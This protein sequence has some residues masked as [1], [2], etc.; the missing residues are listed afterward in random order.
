MFKQLECSE[1]HID[2]SFLYHFTKTKDCRTSLLLNLLI[3][4]DSKQNSRNGTFSCSVFQ[5]SNPWHFTW[6]IVF[7]NFPVPSVGFL[8]CVY[9]A[10]SLDPHFLF[11]LPISPLIFSLLYF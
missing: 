2:S 1:W 5:S 3:F 6:G 8:T 10:T 9:S 11:G 4:V 7:L